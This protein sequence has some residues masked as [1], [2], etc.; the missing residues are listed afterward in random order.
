MDLS[1]LV[2]HPCNLPSHNS[3]VNPKKTHFASQGAVLSGCTLIEQNRHGSF[4]FANK[5][6][7]SAARTPLIFASNSSLFALKTSRRFE[8][9]EAYFQ[10]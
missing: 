6:V 10:S 5:L 9:I 8:L 2:L 7:F 3:E 1:R 4:P